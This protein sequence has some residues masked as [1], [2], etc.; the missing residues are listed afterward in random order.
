MAIQSQIYLKVKL[1]IEGIKA[2]FVVFSQ[3]GGI[4]ISARSYGEINVQL[5]MENLGGGG[6]Q[7]MSACQLGDISFTDAELILKKAIDDYYDNL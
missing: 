5:I 7:T 3:G 6:H 4:N 2:S 1:N